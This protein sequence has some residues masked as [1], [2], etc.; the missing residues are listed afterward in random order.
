MET[1]LEKHW[2]HL[3]SDQTA[4]L[5]SVNE[6]K[7]LD[8]FEVEKR[9][10]HFGR[11]EISGKRSKTPLERF[12]L[13][14]HQPL[15]YI[16][17]AAGII[18]A[19]LQE[20]VDAGVILGVVIVNALVGFFQESKAVKALNSLAESM[21]VEAT[22]LR[23]GETQ[24]IDAAQLVPGDVV[25][26]R[27]GDKVPADLRILSARELRVDESTLTGES[28]PVEKRSGACPTD[29]VLAERTCM[30]FAGTLVNYGQGQGLVVATGN[31]TEIG[32]ISGMVDSADELETPLT[33]KITSF[34]HT[35]LIAILVLA[36]ASFLLG[37]LRDEPAAEMFMAAVALAVG[38]IPEGLPAAVTIILAL[39]VSRMAGRKAIVRKLPAVETLGGTTVICSDKTGTLTE[40]Q[41]TVQAIYAGSQ[42][43]AVSGTGYAPE[44]EVSARDGA[45]LGNAALA[46]CLRAGLLC[47]D[48]QL[49]PDSGR[50]VA[51]GDPTEAALLVSAQKFGLSRNDETVSAP[52]TD[53]IPFESELQYMVTLHRRGERGVAYMKGA[54]ERV[55]D[56]CDTAM[57]PDGNTAELDV[58]AILEMQNTMAARGL[59]VLALARKETAPEALDRGELSSGL[60]F[61]GLQ[62][63]IDPPRAEVMEAIA[64]CH[65]AG[66]AVKMITGDHAVTAQAI[67]TQL[68]L[69]GGPGLPGQACP[70][71]TG[72]EIAELNDKQL[73]Q[74]V[75]DIPVFARVSP[76][77]KLRLVMAMQALGE[78]CAMTGDGVNDA[79]ALKQAD[80][81]IAMGISGTETAKESADMVLTDDNFATIEAAVE[82][83]RC[84]FSN[85]VKFIAWTLPTNAGE[86]LVIL[87]AILFGAT[88][89]I[90]PV[91]ILWINMTT[92]ACL[93]MMLAFEPMEQGIMQRPPRRP[94]RP[95]LDKV[96]LKRV[97][98]VSVILLVAAFGLFEWELRSGASLE[99]ARTMAVNVFIVVEAFY[100]FNARSFRRSPFA[101]GLRTN[102]W[103][104]LGVGVMLLFQLAYTYAPIMNTLFSSAPIGW[105]DWAKIAFCGAVA[106][107]LVELDKKRTHTDL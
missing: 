29:A 23:A 13:Q 38:A 71:L 47:N 84:V 60:V 58:D 32:L 35:L 59:R 55:L 62:G 16:L 28:V 61:L 103:V 73:I 42:S 88:L 100:L 8:R 44:G 5:F 96:I 22:V 92:A 54:V 17:L 81:G 101:L 15:I 80:I 40:N 37:L 43:F 2:H 94:D 69:C 82:E 65:K 97:G 45:D 33:R 86:G 21:R 72:R 11:N 106:F 19:F 50:L 46:E 24:R 53:E 25:L 64:A 34:S 1:L 41:M 48:A 10:E 93:G 20:W 87:T 74:R 56:C 107:T 9:L 39:G 36:G 89:P 90:L 26:L 68:G 66:V 105:L 77:Q 75:A 104:P 57:G 85:L 95:I 18:T 52:R 76:E 99:K 83:G 70:V 51:E 31:R 14:F 91:Q 78:I 79:P 7:G 98:M 27:S 49:R 67:G 30:A 6:E 102:P 3:S 12:L 4:E 63:M